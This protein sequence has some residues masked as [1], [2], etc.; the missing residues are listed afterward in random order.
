MCN[1]YNRSLQFKHGASDYDY[2]DTN[3]IQTR[4]E[5]NDQHLN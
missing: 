5:E 2:Y 1:D 4:K 3:F